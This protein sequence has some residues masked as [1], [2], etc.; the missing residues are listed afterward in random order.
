[1][2]TSIACT[3]T[4]QRVLTFTLLS[5]LNRPGRDGGNS[6]R[7]VFLSLPFTDVQSQVSLDCPENSL[8]F[9]TCSI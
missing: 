7:R 9:Q 8:I 5:F 1:M 2:Y 3:S 4:F 6:W